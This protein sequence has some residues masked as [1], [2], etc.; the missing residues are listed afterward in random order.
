MD[1]DLICV[2]GEGQL[3]EMDTPAA[4]LRNPQ[5]AFSALVAEA[6]ATQ[7]VGDS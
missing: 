1:S 3:L 7:A 2:L 5:S 4:L 6:Q